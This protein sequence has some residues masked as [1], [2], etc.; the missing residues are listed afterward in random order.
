MRSLFLIGLGILIGTVT[1]G[2]Q[3]GRHDGGAD[4]R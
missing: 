4:H 3:R 1:L 2:G